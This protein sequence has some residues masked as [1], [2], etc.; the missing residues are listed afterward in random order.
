MLGSCC[1]KLPF[2]SQRLHIMKFYFLLRSWSALSKW[3]LKDPALPRCGPIIVDLLVPRCVDRGV[4]RILGDFRDQAQ[5]AIY[6]F[7]YILLAETGHRAISDCKKRQENVKG[8]EE[9]NAHP[10]FGALCNYRWRLV[11]WNASTRHN[12][13]MQWEPSPTWHPA[14]I[15]PSEKNGFIA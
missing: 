1:N 15:P 3:W 10:V 11:P 14:S 2:K 13:S 4:W 7:P 5:R 12:E 9:V 6:H 8:K